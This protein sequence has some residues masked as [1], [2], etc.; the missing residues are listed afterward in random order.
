M[1]RIP[2][3]NLNASFFHVMVQGIKKE[4]IFKESTC[5]EKYLNLIERYQANC[6]IDVLSYCIMNNHTH[7]LLHT[8]EISNMSKFMHKVNTEYAKFYNDISNGRVGYVFR[9][10]F[11]SEPITNNEYLFQC[12][13]YI[14]NNPVKAEIV[15][16]CKDYKYSSYKN[17]LNGYIFKILSKLLNMNVDM[18]TLNSYNKEGIFYDIDISTNYIISNR[19]NDFIQISNMSKEYVFDDKIIFAY[20]IK[21]LSNYKIKAIDIMHFFNITS[22]SFYIYKNTI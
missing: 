9:D 15:S 6:K 17:Y 10:R 21:Y 5:K 18:S 4:Q 19:I 3:N 1:A 22:K 20:L 16:E 13:N 7:M 2:R 14:H 8:K 11:L 12:I